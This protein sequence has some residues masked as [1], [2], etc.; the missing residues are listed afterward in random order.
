LFKDR[1]VETNGSALDTIAHIIL[2][3]LPITARVTGA[4]ET[5]GKAA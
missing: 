3:A 4:V 5:F 2:V 1:A